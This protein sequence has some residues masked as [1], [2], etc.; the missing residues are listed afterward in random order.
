M[1]SLVFFMVSFFWSC[2][3][4]E[5]VLLKFVFSN[6]K[7]ELFFINVI[8]RFWMFLFLF[9]KVFF[10]YF[11]LVWSWSLS[12]FIVFCFFWIFSL[13]FFIC[14]DCLVYCFWCCLSW[15]VS[16]RGNKYFVKLIYRLIIFCLYKFYCLNKF[17]RFSEDRV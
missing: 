9:F 7:L 8:W 11:W 5:F 2:C 1:V 3:I 10:W 12:D 14:W 15:F 4:W 6:L 13:R 17:N 16:F